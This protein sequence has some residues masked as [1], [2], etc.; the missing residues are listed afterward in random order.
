MRARRAARGARGGAR[1]AQ[2]ARAPLRAGEAVGGASPLRALL[3]ERPA[4]A[5]AALLLCA[6]LLD[7]SAGSLGL[8]SELR[9]ALAALDGAARGGDV[10]TLR[11]A[12]DAAR[13]TVGCAAPEGT[14]ADYDWR[15]RPLATAAQALRAREAA[16]ADAA[17]AKSDAVALGKL[18]P[19]RA[20]HV[21]RDGGGHC[22]WAF[23][24]EREYGY[25][26]HR[27]WVQPV[28]YTHLTLPTILLV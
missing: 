17:A 22:Y 1:G 11:D 15:L 18:P 8:A 19:L 4:C 7:A 2:R 21:G 16:D 13:H 25:A 9:A 5:A 10:A 3:R 14:P 27:V 20:D 24:G 23:R 28:S 26:P 6:A 12:L